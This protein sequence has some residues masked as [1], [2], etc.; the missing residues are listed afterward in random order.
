MQTCQTLQTATLINFISLSLF[1]H[2]LH[3]IRVHV[4]HSTDQHGS[5]TTTSSVRPTRPSVRIRMVVVVIGRRTDVRR[6]AHVVQPS[7]ALVMLL[8]LRMALLLLLLLL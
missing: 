4:R 6:M 1:T 3:E 2:H 7:A 8:L 5:T